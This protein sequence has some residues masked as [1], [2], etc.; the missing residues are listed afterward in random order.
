MD[1]I[2]IVGVSIV[3][4]YCMIQL[5]NFFNI[6]KSVYAPYILFYIIMM[7]SVLILPNSYP[8]V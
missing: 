2:T 8:E 3:F 6:N 5:L 1:Y 7:I 4:I